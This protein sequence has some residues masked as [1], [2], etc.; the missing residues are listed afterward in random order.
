VENFQMSPI[1]AMMVEGG[2][3]YKNKLKLLRLQSKN[4]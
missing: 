4:V 3:G 2:V 1:R